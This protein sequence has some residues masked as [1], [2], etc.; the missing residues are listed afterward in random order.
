MYTQDSVS[1][2]ACNRLKSTQLQPTC[3]LDSVDN[4]WQP[5]TFIKLDN[6]GQTN[7][8][9]QPTMVEMTRLFSTMWFCS[10]N[11]GPRVH[12]VSPDEP[13]TV[14]FCP[15][16]LPRTWNF[17]PNLGPGSEPQRIV[18]G[19]IGK[20][21]A[22]WAASELSMH[23]ANVSQDDSVGN[24]TT[25]ALQWQWM[26]LDQILICIKV[27]REPSRNHQ[28]KSQTPHE[29]RQHLEIWVVK[30]LIIC[31]G[32]VYTAR[33]S[34]QTKPG[35]WS[36]VFCCS[37][38]SKLYSCSLVKVSTWSSGFSDTG[39]QA[40]QV[41]KKLPFTWCCHMLSYFIVVY[42]HFPHGK[43]HANTWKL[44]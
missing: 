28:P 25:L 21:W 34:D 22:A 20:G 38:V 19:T 36:L 4:I 32:R 24:G 5:W 11:G 44:P 43:I 17:F 2:T 40:H 37:S 29:A 26:Q 7:H 33:N 13:H 23:S 35:H 41:A 16:A 8:S 27:L 10:R 18:D 30:L 1:L 6:H 14:T 42:H 15:C 12:V 31:P 9:C 3:P 39:C